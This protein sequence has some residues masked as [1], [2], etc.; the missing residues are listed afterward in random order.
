M[1]DSKITLW[2]QY[3]LAALVLAASWFCLIGVPGADGKL[4]GGYAIKAVASA[5]CDFINPEFKECK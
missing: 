5:Y 1:N 4:Q 3:V 2:S